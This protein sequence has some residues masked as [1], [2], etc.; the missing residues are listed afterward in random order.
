[1]KNNSMPSTVWRVEYVGHPLLEQIPLPELDAL[2]IRPLQVGILPG[3]RRKEI[4]SL[5]PEFVRA[6]E[7][8]LKRKPELRFTVAQAPGV[9]EAALRAHLPPEMP[10]TVAPPE[11][12]Y[13]LMRESALLMAAS[14]TATLEAALIGTP[15][16]VAYK[17]SALTY[18]VGRLIIDVPFISLPNLIMK[19]QIFPELLQ[20]KANGP[21]I[22]ARALAW[23]GKRDG[24]RAGAGPAFPAQGDDGDPGRSRPGRPDYF[25]HACVPGAKITSLFRGGQTSEGPGHPCIPN[26]IVHT[27]IASLGVLSVGNMLV[28]RPPP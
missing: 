11:D 28:T 9:D 3:S 15:T 21:D 26:D 14:G 10:F 13:R 7:L 24:S 8:L 23:P 19:E 5:L 1:M 12:R 6:A 2:P 25:G 17:L 18:R 16:I 22:A 4:N 20:E 27:G